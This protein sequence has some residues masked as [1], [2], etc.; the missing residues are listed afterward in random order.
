MVSDPVDLDE[1]TICVP[2]NVPPKKYFLNEFIL[3]R[4]Q[5]LAETDVEYISG[6]IASRR[7]FLIWRVPSNHCHDQNDNCL[8][9]NVRKRFS[10]MIVMKFQRSEEN[11]IYHS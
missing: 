8:F 1:T 11:S 5:A 4:Q 9:S 2:R 10:L 7:S 3:P 6:G